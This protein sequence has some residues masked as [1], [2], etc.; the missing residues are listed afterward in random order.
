MIQKVLWHSLIA[1]PAFLGLTLLASGSAGA[2]QPNSEAAKAT[3]PDAQETLI[4]STAASTASA[5]VAEPQADTK[6]SQLD[7]IR[8]YATDT[9][10]VSAS[11]AAEA[12]AAVTGSAPLQQIRSYS[13]TSESGQIG[14]VT[15]VTQLSDV[16]PTDWAFAALQSLVEKYGCIAG[17]PDR[18]YRGNRAMTRFEAAAALNAC[19]ERVNELMAQG[20]ADKVSKEDLA[21]VIKLQEEF[22]EELDQLKG[23]VDSLEVRTA[24]LERQQFSTTTKLSGEVIFSL[25][26]ANSDN[27]LSAVPNPYIPS[28]P[29]PT[30]GTTALAASLA[31]ATGVPAARFIPGSNVYY[32]Q[33]SSI[34][35]ALVMS[36]R[37]RLNFDTSFTPGDRL[38]IR[39]Q[40]GNV[41]NYGTGVTG[42]NMTRLGYDVAG[43]T[44]ADN[45]NFTLH[46]LQYRFPV[47]GKGRI[48]VD[49]NAAEL[50]DVFQS[51]S[52]FVSGGAGAV[53]RFGRFNP[54][55]RLPGTA[56]ASFEYPFTDWFHFQVGYYS[57]DPSNPSDGA[58][59]DGSSQTFLGQ[60]TFKPLEN[61]SFALLY[62]NAYFTTTTNSAAINLTGSTGSG[63]A[64]NPF[65][66]LFGG[67]TGTTQ[68]TTIRASSDNY[69]FQFNWRALPKFILAGWVGFQDAVAESPVP[70]IGLSASMINW[71]LQFGFPDVINKGDLGG[72]VVGQP[73]LVTS[74]SFR[75]P[76]QGATPAGGPAFRN[77]GEA[78]WHIEAFY[79]YTLTSNISVTPGIIAIVNPENNGNNPTVWVGVIRTTFTF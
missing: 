43:A 64:S 10:P 17:Y 68:L 73:Y 42:T 20:L 14:Q 11:T 12:P 39:L 56:G 28:A 2:L 74:N 21:A 9:A 34:G 32:G 7:Q 33:S 30:T 46:T 41:P 37:V 31:T 57:A 29:L 77:D 4:A 36:N 66:P 38:R 70:G 54:I 26:G 35:D 71:A 1:A 23:K 52:P 60:A 22:R 72:I 25:S 53:S 76:V 18:T 62:G 19:M 51:L 8:S 5:P 3:Q 47:F 40:S 50:N 49:A 16:K 55:Y 75:S 58:G 24:K 67:A 27:G 59:I 48:T 13:N 65:N 63:F 79:R 61:L 69:A 44:G 45:P 78:A 15:S 6:I